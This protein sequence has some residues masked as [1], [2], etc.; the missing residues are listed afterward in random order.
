MTLS[1]LPLSGHSLERRPRA[2]HAHGAAAASVDNLGHTAHLSCQRNVTMLSNVKFR[3]FSR[4]PNGKS[5]ALCAT[6]FSVYSSED[7]RATIARK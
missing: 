3:L 2:R 5:H 7:A 1:Y 4:H 6:E